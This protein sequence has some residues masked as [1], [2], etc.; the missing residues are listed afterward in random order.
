MTKLTP[1]LYEKNWS[2]G[3]ADVLP[4]QGSNNEQDFLVRYIMIHPVLVSNTSSKNK[5]QT[6][7]Y[8][9]WGQKRY[10]PTLRKQ[11]NFPL[12]TVSR[13]KHKVS[14]KTSWTAF[15][16]WYFRNPHWMMMLQC[17]NFTAAGQWCNLK[18]SIYMYHIA[19]FMWFNLNTPTSLP[20]C[21]ATGLHG[22]SI[23]KQSLKLT[24]A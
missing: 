7:C 18:L 16:S 5:P 19:I 1:R 21:F 13:T 15:P 2:C 24:V 3:K 4:A 6:F 9:G 17:W 10:C 12:V 14:A 8:S 11:W 22:N 20:L 23:P